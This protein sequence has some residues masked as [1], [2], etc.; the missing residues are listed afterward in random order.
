MIT[1]EKLD[2]PRGLICHKAALLSFFK[3]PGE[4]AE[5]QPRVES[6]GRESSRGSQPSARSARWGSGWSAG[7]QGGPEAARGVGWPGE[8]APGA[9]PGCRLPS[10]PL[11]AAGSGKSR[12]PASH[13]PARSPA[14]PGCARLPRTR[15]H[16]ARK[17]PRR[18]SGE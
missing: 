1:F 16:L 7:D 6:P 12:S 14:R 4:H 11:P 13:Q 18:D 9:S 17:A 15:S 10:Q 3:H 2:P 5:S 8:A